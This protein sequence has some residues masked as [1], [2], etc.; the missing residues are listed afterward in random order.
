VIKE[1]IDFF[2]SDNFMPHGHCF[3]WQ[4]NILWLHVLSDA[5]IALAYF[6]IPFALIYFVLK[7]KDLPFQTVF[8]LFGA[9]ILLCGSTHLLS[10]WVLWYPN[11]AFEGIVKALTAIVSIITFFMLLKLIPK[12]LLLPSPVQ[13]AFLN[14]ELSEANSKLEAM[15]EQQRRS[16]QSHLRAVVDYAIDGLITINDSGIVQSFNPACQRIFGY[17]AE[18]IIGQ[19]IKVLMPEPYHS[20]HDDYLSHYL[21][22]G[23]AKIIGTS[24]REVRAKRKDGSIFPMDLSV[25]SFQLEGQQYFS[26]IIRDITERKDVEAKLRSHTNYLRAV[27][28]HAIDGLITINEQGIVR[29]FNPACERIFGYN[30]EE[31]IGN[32]I[33][34][35]MPEPYHSEH[36]HYL[37][38]YLTTGDAKIIG[39]AGREVRA[40]RKDGTI[41]PMDLSVSS[42]Q[43]EDG[44][45]FS[46]IIRD[47]TERKDVEAK[48]ISYMKELESSNKEL[49][50]FAYIASHDLKEP[51]RGIHNHSRF[52]LE[53]NEGKLDADSVGRLGRLV[54]LSQRM[55]KLVNDLL[56]FSRLGRQELAIQSTDINHVIADIESTLDV[57]LEEHHVQITIPETLPTIT[58]DRLRVTEA[59]RN[60]ITNAIKYNDKPEKIIEIGFLSQFEGFTHVFYVKDNGIGIPVEFYNEV[61]RIFKRLQS[62]KTNEEEG[63][64]VGLTFVKKIIERHGGRIWLHS[65]MG[66]GTSFYFTLGE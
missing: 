15:Y 38:H 10:I 46:G 36:D 49:D 43:L 35:L 64:G 31:I 55:E 61:F 63:T 59:F 60:L 2:N 3:L 1:I 26:G 58:C 18:E 29:S 41:F 28:D 24:G 34:M 66:K 21:H 8:I 56:Y 45:Y 33:K 53:D 51:L 30:A 47:I 48:L 22:T 25:S 6:S 57:M 4:P 65:E 7:R 32:N 50:D 20:E 39:T 19:N 17:K 9:F 44:R 16:G 13:L 42:F 62:S 11:Y 37:K 5:G 52:L 14:G 54:Y 40:K 12:A 23:D 27:V